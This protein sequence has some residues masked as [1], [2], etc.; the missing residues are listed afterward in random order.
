MRLGVRLTT[1]GRVGGVKGLF[2]SG[3]QLLAWCAGRQCLQM[4]MDK[5]EL[6]TLLD[7]TAG[8][9]GNC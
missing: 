9:E 4:K 3:F 7:V 1:V 2:V 6:F 5:K 8:K